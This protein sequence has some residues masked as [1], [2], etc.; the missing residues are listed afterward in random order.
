VLLIAK[1]TGLIE[2]VKPPLA[3]LRQ[4]DFRVS[5]RVLDEVL[6]RAGEL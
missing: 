2:A 1:Q 6:A 5:A 3:A 4:T